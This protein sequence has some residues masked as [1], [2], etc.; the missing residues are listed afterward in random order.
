MSLYF[1]SDFHLGAGDEKNEARKYRLFLKFLEKEREEIEQLVILGD[2]FDFWLEYRHLIPKRH[3]HILFKLHDLV[4]SGIKV[5]YI[6]G[7]HDYWMGDFLHKELGI[8]HVPDKIEINTPQGTILAMHGDGLFQSDRTYRFFRGMLHNR[9][10]VAL[11]RLLPPTLAYFLAHRISGTSRK[12]SSQYPAEGFLERYYQFAQSKF[13][14][15]YFAFICGH[16]HYP[17]IRQFGGNY[18]V[19]SG[20]WIT[21]FCYVRYSEGRFELRSV[22]ED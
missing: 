8:E 12:H 19:N 10:N 2:L 3:L 20:D 18:Y 5:Q 4:R 13:E 22:T 6:A 16:T 21:N 9:F 1:L 7:N 15:G 11:Y 14:E 17:E